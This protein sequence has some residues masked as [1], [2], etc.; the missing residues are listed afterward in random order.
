MTVFI[1]MRHVLHVIGRPLIRILKTKLL[2]SYTVTC[3]SEFAKTLTDSQLWYLPRY[4]FCHLQ[5]YEKYGLNC[6][7]FFFTKLASTEPNCTQISCSEFITIRQMNVKVRVQIQRRVEV[8]VHR[9]SRNVVTPIF[10][11]LNYYTDFHE[12]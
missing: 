10:T 3:C 7:D 5:P 8:K 9:F 2:M 11:K 12:T 1:F 4:A 6:A